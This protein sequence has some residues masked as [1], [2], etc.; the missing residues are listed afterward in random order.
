MS[1]KVYAYLWE[2]LGDNGEYEN[3]DQDFDA[4]AR[5]ARGVRST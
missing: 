4:A 1:K 2:R 3:F 5:A